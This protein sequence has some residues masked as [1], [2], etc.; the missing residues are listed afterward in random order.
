MYVYNDPYYTY[1]VCKYSIGPM[2][3]TPGSRVSLSHW[4]VLRPAGR[5]SK[6]VLDSRFRRHGLREV[7]RNSLQFSS[8]SL[9]KL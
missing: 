3:S 4:R 5:G 6:I 2:G 7:G 1:T 9:Y 8:V